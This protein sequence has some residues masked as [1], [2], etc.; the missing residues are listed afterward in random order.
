MWLVAG[1]N[2][3]DVLF[4]VAE[5]ESDGGTRDV[6]Y[7]TSTTWDFS[8]SEPGNISSALGDLRGPLCI[9]TLSGADLGS[10]PDFPV[11][12]TN[13]YTEDNT[14]SSS[15]VPVLGEDCV[16]ALVSEDGGAIYPYTDGSICDGPTKKWTE[17]PECASSFGYAGSTSRSIN[18]EVHQP[19]LNN[20][21]SDSGYGFHG[22]ISENLEAPR[23]REYISATNQLQVLMINVNLQAGANGAVMGE[24]E[25]LC[26]RVNTTELRDVDLDGDG[27]AITSE[28]VFEGNNGHALR[29]GSVWIAF[30]SA[31]LV[32]L[33]TC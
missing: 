20:S 27:V 31:F 26:M 30:L 28:V 15:C 2:V 32:I 1:V 29:C 11:N 10:G 18:Q 6:T 16:R 9:A 25:L 8:W 17:I 4:P 22:F 21:A 5:S 19:S 24:P 23:S 14:G 3:S 7:A 33:A 13:A 12:V